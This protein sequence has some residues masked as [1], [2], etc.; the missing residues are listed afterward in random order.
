[1]GWE[2]LAT[3]AGGL[4]ASTL[5]SSAM[6]KPPKVNSSAATSEIDTA[7]QKSKTARTAL[8]ETAGGQAGAQLQPGQVANSRD[9][10]LG[11]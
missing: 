3:A 8:L 2:T 6:K 9:T 10:I 4:L 7:A 11:N 5:F 1:M